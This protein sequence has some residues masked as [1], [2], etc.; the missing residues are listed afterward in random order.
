MSR[1][2]SWCCLAYSSADDLER[3]MKTLC[4]EELF[5]EEE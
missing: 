3:L 4:G 2:M 1:P 5:S